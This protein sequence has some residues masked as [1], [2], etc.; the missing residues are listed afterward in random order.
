MRIHPILLSRGQID[1]TFWDQLIRQSRQCVIYAFSGYLDIVCPHWE[2]FVWPCATAFSMVMPLPLSRRFGRRVVSQPLFCQYLGVFSERDVSRDELH[3]FQDALRSR[4]AYISS[5]AFNPENTACFS[6]G[7]ACMTLTHWLDLHKPYEAIFEHYSNDKK[8][9]V[10]RGRRAGWEL[11]TS[12]DCEPLIG[13]FSAHHAAGIGQIDRR[14]FDVLRR[15]VGYCL[16][17][18]L[19]V[20]MY[21]RRGEVI[22]A[23]ILIVRQGPRASYLFNAAS[24]AGRKGQARAW[25]LDKFFRETAGQD[26][27]FDFESPS[28]ASIAEY[29]QGFGARAVHYLTIRQNA[30]PFP[31]R[32]LVRFRQRLLIRTS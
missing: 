17:Q 29:Y 5:Y 14:A 20:L 25:M 32:Q 3:A 4:Y 13:L 18:E 19:G 28:K 6:P 22:E 16:A 2:A 10:K 31:L 26:L 15:L 11:V 1:A 9:N 27:I 23:G 21:A 24:V 12:T 8:L 7:S 30:L